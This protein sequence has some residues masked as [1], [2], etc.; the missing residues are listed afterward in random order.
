VNK[1]ITTYLDGMG[2][3]HA[4]LG[5]AYLVEAIDICLDDRSAINKMTVK[6]GIYTRVA[7]TY[8]TTP[9][10][11]ER[12]MRHAIESADFTIGNLNGKLPNSEFI[13][14]AVD[15]IRDV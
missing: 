10:R 14:R 1:R 12:A 11:V 2:F 13:A 9:S 5:F 7:N 6:G 8:I 4:I 15:E 3:K